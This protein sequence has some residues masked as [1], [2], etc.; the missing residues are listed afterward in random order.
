MTVI[1]FT[2]MVGTGHVDSHMAQVVSDLTMPVVPRRQRAREGEAVGTGSDIYSAG[3]VGLTLALR[4]PRSSAQYTEAQL[5]LEQHLAIPTGYTAGLH[6]LVLWM[7]AGGPAP[8]CHGMS[9]YLSA[10]QAT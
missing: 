4:L 10:L 3:R 2:A 7:T 8:H 9:R 5:S 6:Q 1:D